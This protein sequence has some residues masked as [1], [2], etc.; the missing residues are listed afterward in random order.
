MISKQHIAIAELLIDLEAEMRQKSL[1]SEKVPSEEAL[2][3]TEP[4][5]VDT[6]TFVEWLQFVFVMRMKIIAEEGMSLPRKSDIVPM[7]E[8][9][10][11]GTAH[12]PLRLFELLGEID[13]ILSE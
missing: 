11:R 5:C 9:H 10:F 12:P 1:W 3:S 8:E 2:S 4:F 13:Q 6:L 7:A